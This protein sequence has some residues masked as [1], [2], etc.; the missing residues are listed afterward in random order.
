MIDIEY[1]QQI[2]SF[3]IRYI[4]ENLVAYSYHDKINIGDLVVFRERSFDNYPEKI[5][6]VVI[7][8][9]IT[10]DSWYDILNIGLSKTNYI[11]EIPVSGPWKKLHSTGTLPNIMAEDRSKHI[12]SIPGN[13]NYL[14]NLSFSDRVDLAGIINNYKQEYNNG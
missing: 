9:S 3:P 2:E 7:H 12:M 4:T 13:I 6:G 14:E 11:V 5:R 10:E 1:D 8:M